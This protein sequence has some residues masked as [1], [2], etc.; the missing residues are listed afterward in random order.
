MLLILISAITSIPALA[1]NENVKAF[2]G[3]ELYDTPEI[4]IKHLGLEPGQGQ[5][6]RN[7]Y[8]N[9]P[10]DKAGLD[11]DDVLIGLEGNKIASQQEFIGTM[12]NSQPGA[13]IKLE[14]IQGGKRKDVTLKLGKAPEN[15]DTAQW[16]Y[17]AEQSGMQVVRPGKVYQL[18][19][20]EKN[21]H[22][23][24]MSEL[25]KILPQRYIFSHNEDN[26]ECKVTIKGDPFDANTEVLIENKN[27]IFKMK[28]GA[29]NKTPEKDEVEIPEMYKRIASKYIE[30]AKELARD[31]KYH[32]DYGMDFSSINLP[33]VDA[34]SLESLQGKLQPYLEKMNEGKDK[35]I[36]KMNDSMEMLKDQVTQLQEK[37]DQLLNRTEMIDE[38]SGEKT[39]KPEKTNKQQQNE[40][41]ISQEGK[42]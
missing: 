19:P 36:E 23:M 16:K 41:P 10:A 24:Y 26:V 11:R 13:K 3:V 7:V 21:W 32:F 29:V 34:L 14:V 40:T 6:I 37:L 35:Q 27:E 2:L 17:P 28:I 1:N 12:Q 33:D 39:E 42:V 5:V 18:S 8:L 30:E 25:Y 15:F 31:K 9:S 38:L 22:E 20:D 4:L